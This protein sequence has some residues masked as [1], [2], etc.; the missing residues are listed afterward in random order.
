[1]TNHRERLR[2][3]LVKR[4]LN[5]D[6]VDFLLT[7]NRQWLRDRSSHDA[8]SLAQSIL[9]SRTRC[10]PLADAVAALTPV[11][12]ES[13]LNRVAR[14]ID[15]ECFGAGVEAAIMGIP[16]AMNHFSSRD[17]LVFSSGASVGNRPL[18][19]MLPQP[20]TNW[21]CLGDTA[22]L[23]RSAIL[24]GSM[25]TL[26]REHS[27]FA[28]IE[29]RYSSYSEDEL[30][31]PMAAATTPYEG[32]VAG[33]FTRGIIHPELEVYGSFSLENYTVT[34]LSLA[35]IERPADTARFHHLYGLGGAWAGIDHLRGCVHC[36]RRALGETQSY[37]TQRDHS[38]MVAHTEAWAADSAGFVLP[39]YSQELPMAPSSVEYVPVPPANAQTFVGYYIVGPGEPTVTTGI[40]NTFVNAS[41][42]STRWPVHYPDTA[43]GLTQADHNPEEET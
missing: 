31:Y 16:N 13:L 43:T 22:T 23:S 37:I 34:L 4:G 41:S 32:L 26:A 42:T 30:F 15:E 2:R 7:H 19:S 36:H 6:Q 35:S 40:T 29:P 1:V 10:G 14:A 27:G 18:P 28:R 21:A 24:I 12:R 33:I 39:D 5:E 38:N 20:A 17:Q 3:I 11:E 8:Y 9:S 25:L